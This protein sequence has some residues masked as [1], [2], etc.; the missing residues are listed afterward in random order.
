MQRWSASSQ[1]DSRR[2]DRRSGST[3]IC[4]G[5]KHA[6]SH[7]PRRRQSPRTTHAGS[8]TPARASFSST[9]I[10]CRRC[11]RSSAQLPGMTLLDAQAVVGARS[12]RGGRIH[13]CRRR[14]HSPARWKTS[15]SRSSRT[16]WCSTSPQVRSRTS[17]STSCT[18]GA[19][20]PRS[21]M[22]NP[23]VVVRAGANS[24]CVV[25]EHFVGATSRRMLHER[26]LRHRGRG[27]R[28]R[29]ALPAS[30]R[31]RRAASTSG[32]STFACS[33]TAATHRTTSRWARAWP[34]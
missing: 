18:T 26:R 4:A 31:S 2:S 27:R 14:A 23:R 25:I 20:R 17:R 21:V 29:R 22:S 30:S 32:T 16:A 1:P 8:R 24:R 11:R 10:G 19:T 15:T 12:R 9:G 3:R 13:R 7:R 28:E 33:R 5:S 6:R 34:A